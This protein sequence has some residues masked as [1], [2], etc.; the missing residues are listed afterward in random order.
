MSFYEL[1]D[2]VQHGQSTKQNV[3]K[4][5]KSGQVAAAGP[6]LLAIQNMLKSTTETGEIGMFAQRPPRI[7]RS[8]TQSSL[9]MRSRRHHRPELD[10]QRGPSQTRRPST[11]S[12]RGLSRSGTVR[13]SQTASQYQPRSRRP[14]PRPG[15]HP[16]QHPAYPFGRHNTYSHGSLTSVGIA[17]VGGN[18]PSSY[19][20]SYH[21]ASGQRLGR[22]V[23][24]ALSNTYEYRNPARHIARHHS[25]GTAPS[26]PGSIISF[27]P[28]LRNYRS[29][30]N[31][32]FA[33]FRPLPS[34][35]ISTIRYQRSRYNYLRN[36]TP[37]SATRPP[38]RFGSRASLDSPSASST[39]SIVPFYYD[40][41]ESFHGADGLVRLSAHHPTIPEV[42]V[43]QEQD[44]R[45]HEPRD[46]EAQDPFSTKLAS[47][48]SQTELPTRHNRRASEQ[49]TQFRHSRRTSD[50][51]NLSVRLFSQTIEEHSAHRQEDEQHVELGARETQ[52]CGRC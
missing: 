51:S 44:D 19:A 23:S 1:S 37:S 38:Q 16:Y 2:N 26:S 31:G 4:D 12:A 24:P 28:S 17:T 7:P 3:S 41:S 33:S 10:H 46:A 45:Q 43:D 21:S 32:S 15:T 40:Y 35:G 8:N 20:R 13:T 47:S 36:P 34:P 52:V 39:G 11:A 25:F 50:K 29:E 49:S 30:H 42:A 6:P 48:F 27:G 5:I 22:A 14:R 18:L 9:G